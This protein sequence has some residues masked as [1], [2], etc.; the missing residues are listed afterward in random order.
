MN[1]AD[2]KQLINIVYYLKRIDR[3]LAL[4]QEKIEN[5]RS[6]L[7][8]WRIEMEKINRASKGSHRARIHMR[9]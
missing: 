2:Y 4:Q 9:D 5:M 8:R 1:E 7:K 6:L 3:E